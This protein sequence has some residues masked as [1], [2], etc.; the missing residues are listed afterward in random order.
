LAAL[1]QLPLCGIDLRRCADGSYVCF[2]VN[3]MPAFSYYEA[4]TG[5]P[6]ARR[7]VEFLS[8]KA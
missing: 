1:L 4:N 5:Q 6:I 3:P 2:E 7:L 8:G